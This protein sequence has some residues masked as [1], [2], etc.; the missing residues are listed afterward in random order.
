MVR[1]GREEFYAELEVLNRDL[2]DRVE[3]LEQQ[4]KHGPFHVVISERT[5]KILGI[6]GSQKDAVIGEKLTNEE[7][8][9]ME[10]TNS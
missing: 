2:Q 5:G 9:I 1:D 7:T 4:L 8:H 3:E 10:V 6:Y